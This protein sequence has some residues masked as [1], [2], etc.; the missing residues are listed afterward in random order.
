MPCRRWTAAIP[1]KRAREQPDEAR[2]HSE[3]GLAY[4]GLGR[5]NEAKREGE[6]AVELLPIS[7][8]ALIGSDWVRNL[9]QIYVM[10]GD[11]DA[12]VEE[13]EYLLSIVAPISGHWLRLD[14]IWDPLRDR[15]QFQALLEE[16]N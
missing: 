7:K 4:A 10:V 15:P 2:F 8:E 12:A 5:K 11:H 3:L 13:L 9:A 14:P 16:R 6:L 1:N